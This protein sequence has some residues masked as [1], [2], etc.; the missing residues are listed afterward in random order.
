M[1]RRLVTLAAATSLLLCV[2]TVALW[3]R[4][5]WASYGLF[6]ATDQDVERRSIVIGIGVAR[7]II[8]GSRSVLTMDRRGHFIHVNELLPPADAGPVF[9]WSLYIRG[10]RAIAPVVPV[11]TWLGF[12]YEKQSTRS[13]PSLQES[14]HASIPLWLPVLLLLLPP[15]FWVTSPARRRER[16]LRLGLCATCGYDLRASP[17]RCPEC[18]AAPAA[19]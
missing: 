17:V 11:T 2:A 19:R 6:R 18:G 13:G 9:G 16:R 8:G 4:S 3:V 15:A 5:Y 10:G 12:S 7:G 1:K 14:L